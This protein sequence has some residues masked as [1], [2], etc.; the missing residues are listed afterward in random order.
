MRVLARDEARHAGTVSGLHCDGAVALLHADDGARPAAGKRPGQPPG[1]QRR[2]RKCE[3][4]LGHDLDIQR[5][6]FREDRAF[7]PRRRA[8]NERHVVPLAEERRD[9][10]HDHP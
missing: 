4:C 9:K 1:Q 5:F 8:V 7:V 6:Q 2:R 3:T 10:M